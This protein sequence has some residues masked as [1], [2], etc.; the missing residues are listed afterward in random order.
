[1]FTRFITTTFFLLTAFLAVGQIDNKNTLTPQQ[2]IKLDNQLHEKIADTS[3][4]KIQIRLAKH[5][6]EKWV[7]EKAEIDSVTSLIRQA[8]EINAGR[9]AGKQTGLIQLYEATLARKIGKIDSARQLVRE[10]ISQFKL[11]NNN[12]G[13]VEGY[14]ELSQYYNSYKPEQAVFIRKIL[15]TIFTIVPKSIPPHQLDSCL[16]TLRNFKILTLYTNDL[17]I[18][19]Y[20]IERIAAVAQMVND[21]ALHFWAKKELPYIHYQQGH[22]N[23]AID[24]VLALVEEQKKVSGSH[25]CYTY[26]RLGFY[27]F[28]GTDYEKSL[29]YALEATKHVTDA[30]DSSGLVEFYQIVATNYKQRGNAAEAVKWNLK[31]IDLMNATQSYDNLYSVLFDLVRDMV[32]LGRAGEAL[33][34]IRE[35]SRKHPPE[36]SWDKIMHMVSLGQVYDALHDYASAEKNSEKLVA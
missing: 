7:P 6:L 36:P 13:L 24:E 34:I 31:L 20:Y 33:K 1:M 18:Q 19:S 15:D 16:A 30:I 4:F 10:A 9:L 8:K 23:K 27:Y 26:A 21:T 5:M 25:I 32:P 2:A 22:L 14:L 3:R 17:A 28:I 35:N 11:S 12:F 29:Y